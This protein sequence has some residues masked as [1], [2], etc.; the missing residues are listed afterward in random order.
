[1]AKKKRRCRK[2]RTRRLVHECLEQ[3]RLLAGDMAASWQNVANALDI[4]GDGDVTPLDAL[5]LVTEFNR[6]GPG[7]LDSPSADGSW[8]VSHVDVDG[9]GALT[10]QDFDAVFTHLNG[11]TQLPDGPRG[12]AASRPAVVDEVCTRS[13]H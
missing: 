4:N 6:N 9:D 1:M 7:P 5:I 11:L 10:V 8:P 2:K 13:V 12:G 3:R